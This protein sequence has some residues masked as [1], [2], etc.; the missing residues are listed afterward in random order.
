LRKKSSAGRSLQ[1][2]DRRICFVQ[3]RRFWRASDLVF[4]Q[5]QSERCALAPLLRKLRAPSVIE[6]G[7]REAWR[8]S[9][10]FSTSTED[11]R[12]LTAPRREVLSRKSGCLGRAVSLRREEESSFSTDRPSLN[13]LPSGR[14]SLL[15]IARRMPRL[16]DH[17]LCL[18]LTHQA[19]TDGSPSPDPPD[20]RGE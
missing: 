2:K 8:A 14:R 17:L 7:A 4:D 5:G 16:L 3:L 1:V 19:E 15:N 13:W 9:R 6:A 12:S 18:V 10:A 11:L 20:F